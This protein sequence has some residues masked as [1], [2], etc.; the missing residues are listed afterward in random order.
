MFLNFLQLVSTAAHPLAYFLDD[1]QWA[2]PASLRLIHA[3]LT[4]PK[5]AHLL[6]IGAYRDNEVGPI[7]P[8]TLAVED[9]RKAGVFISETKLK[10][11]DLA[12]VTQLRAEKLGG[13]P[14]R[15]GPLASLARRKT[16]GNPFFLNQFLSSLAQD[17]NFSISTSAH[18]RLDVGH[19]SDRT[20]G[21]H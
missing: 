17:K 21:G 6:V 13:E 5:R 1:L 16:D 11:L 9:L 7:H 15:I 4:A 3:M 20:G 12:N 14:Q 10:P 8:L 18:P 19:R 2:D